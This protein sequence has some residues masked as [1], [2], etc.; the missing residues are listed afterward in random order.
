MLPLKEEE[1]GKSNLGN[2]RG[3][4]AN[5]LVGKERGIGSSKVEERT[6]VEVV[7]G[8]VADVVVDV[9]AVVVVAVAR[10]SKRLE[11]L[12]AEGATRPWSSLRHLAS[13]E[14]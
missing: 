3:V 6:E 11:R 13:N 10:R 5:D 9:V 7:V 1:Y 8:T 4:G 12:V 14:V 2:R